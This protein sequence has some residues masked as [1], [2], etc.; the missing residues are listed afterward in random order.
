MPQRTRQIRVGPV[1]VGG[2]APVAIQTMAKALPHE[3]DRMVAQLAEARAA[4]CHIARIAVPDRAALDGLAAVRAGSGLPIVADIHFDHR[5]AVAAARAGADGLRINPGNLGGPDALRAVV[6]A[7]GEAAIPIR[8]GVNAGSLPKRAGRRT[9]PSAAAMVDTALGW[10]DQVERLGFTALK[11]SLKAFDV[12]MTVAAYRDF[13]ARSDVP[14]HLGV[15]EAGPPL[16]G[17]VRSSAA[18]AQLLA[19]GVGDTLRISLSAPP[20]TEVRVARTLLGALGL[21]PAPAVVSCPTCGRTRVDLCP[22]AE[23]VERRLEQLGLVRTVAVMGC[24]VNGPGEARAADLGI[25]YGRGARGALFEA[26]RVV[27]RLPN[28]ELEAALVE[29]LAALAAEER[30]G[31]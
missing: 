19:A 11:V 6:E 13:A 5:L 20:A 15:T 7:A 4:G 25:A 12:P 29:R 3:V 23:R 31:G 27:A 18:L 9:P 2:G 26:G 17:A 22:V 8:I 21:A 30:D 24:E 10:V 16:A 28:Q 14:L 1:P